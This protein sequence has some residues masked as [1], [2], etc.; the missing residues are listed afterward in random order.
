MES[1]YKLHWKHSWRDNPFSHAWPYITSPIF[2]FSKPTALIP[3][4]SLHAYVTVFHTR[5]FYYSISTSPTYTTYIYIIP[6]P[7][8]PASMPSILIKPN[9]HLSHPLS[10]P[11]AMPLRPTPYSILLISLHFKFAVFNSFIPNSCRTHHYTLHSCLQL[12]IL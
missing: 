10:T 4:I 2:L 12:T 6:H 7:T 3:L 11:V 5:L 9:L 8:I 1:V